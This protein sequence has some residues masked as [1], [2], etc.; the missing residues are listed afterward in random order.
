MQQSMLK[1]N[2]KNNEAEVLKKSRKKNCANL[3]QY[4]SRPFRDEEPG[5]IPVFKLREFKSV[6][7]LHNTCNSHPL[8]K[9]VIS[10]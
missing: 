8:E 10:L 7:C 6:S 2:F 3:C 1:A 9:S 5:S 4:A